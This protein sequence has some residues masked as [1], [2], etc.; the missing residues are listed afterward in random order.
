MQCPSCNRQPIGLLRFCTFRTRGVSFQ[1]AIK[2]YLKCRNCGT[3]L[4]IEEFN[5]AFLIFMGILFVAFFVYWILL[6]RIIPNVGYK[7]SIGILL[8]WFIFVL[9]GLTYVRWKNA[10]I[11]QS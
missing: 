10:R 9:F 6:S 7:V 2:G 11:K 5:A 8:I 1:Q 3:L 4:Q